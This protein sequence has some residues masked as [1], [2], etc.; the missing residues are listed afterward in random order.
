MRRGRTRLCAAIVATSALAACVVASGQAAAPAPVPTE[1][2]ARPNVVMITLDDLSEA[3]LAV[4][5]RT[6]E[7]LASQGTTMTQ[8]L[9]PTP[10]CAPARASLLT[11][12]YAHNHGV[13]TVEGEAGGAAA[14]DDQRTLPTWLRRVGYDTMFAGKYLNGYGTTNPRYVPPGWNEWR[15]SVDFSTY[16]FFD[17][18]FN[19]NGKVVRPPG[20]NTDILARYTEEMLAKHR[21]GSLRGQPFFLWVNYVAPHHGGPTESD[22]PKQSWPGGHTVATTTPA[23]RHRNLFD[24]AALPH[25]P[26]MWERNRVGN[27][28]AG[29]AAPRGYRAAVREAHQQRLESLQATDQAVG[30][31]VAA[32]R[33][34]GELGNTVIALTSDNGFM[35]GQHNRFGKLWFYDDSVRIPIILRG[36]GI[37][38]GK[39]LSTPITNPDLAVTIAALAKASPTRDVDGVNLVPWL[40]RPAQKRVVPIEA[41]PVAGGR[42]RLYSG[43]RY[44]D[45]TYIRDRTGFEELYDRSR[46]PGEL[47]NV[48]RRPAYRAA[49]VR[50]RTWN[51]RYRNCAGTGCPQGFEPA[52]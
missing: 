44:G 38:R 39:R 21:R 42:T 33:R 13:L 22:D 30:R 23:P 49:V 16:S 25:G 3:D 7:L 14:F 45:L 48:A 8:G 29:S 31:T 26:A 12:Q 2:A 51:N 46:D 6:R 17:T 28:H 37:P 11:G 1:S 10:I 19:I 24:H 15:G 9:A 20:Y 47:V 36:P 50:L 41:Y 4:M 43:I 40:T 18:R 5:P 27:H 52:R 32:L 34:S 35:V